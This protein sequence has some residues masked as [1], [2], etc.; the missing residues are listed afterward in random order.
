MQGFDLQRRLVH[1]ADGD[2]LPYD[3]LILSPGSVTADYGVP[4]VAEH[5]LMLKS[6][7]DAVAIRNHVLT[8]FEKAAERDCDAGALTIV[9]AGGGATGVE[10]AGAMAELAAA[11]FKKDLGS[12][13]RR[14]VRVVL[15]EKRDT[16]LPGFAEASREYTRRTLKEMG[17]EVRLGVGIR[18]V[19]PD[20]VELD[21][22]WVIQ[23]R[24]VVWAAGVRANPLT[25]ALGVPLEPS[26]RVAVEPDLTLPGH[27]EVAVIGDAASI[28]AGFAPSR[29]YGV[30]RLDVSPPDLPGWRPQSAQCGAHV[31]LELPDL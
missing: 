8:Q 15:V 1:L 26:G 21:D 6:V 18:R 29:L 28:P 16:L 30:G 12:I 10:L 24:T 25:R 27:T 13:V 5:A 17:V 19:M 20:R 11:M 2:P 22:G 14:A 4:G 7:G 23:T 31:G 3:H 9:V